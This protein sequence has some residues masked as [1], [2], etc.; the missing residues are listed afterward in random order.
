[1]PKYKY[2]FYDA[3]DEGIDYRDYKRVRELPKN[4]KLTAVA[5]VWG[6]YQDIRCLF[7]SESNKRYCRTGFFSTKYLIKELNVFGNEIEVGQKF[8]T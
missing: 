1:M 8:E 6:N 3:L 2:S 5:G 7:I 4:E